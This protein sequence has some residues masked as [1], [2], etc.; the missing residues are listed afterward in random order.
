VLKSGEFKP[1]ADRPYK[2]R[3]GPEHVQ[4][5]QAQFQEK[6]SMMGRFVCLS[7]IDVPG[8]ETIPLQDDLPGWWSK[9]ELF[10]V[11]RRVAYV[12]LDTVI[13]GDPSRYL[14]QNEKR[15]MVS[16]GIHIL[17][18]GA[19]NTSLMAWD[20][21][22][23]WVYDRFMQDPR[24]VMESYVTQCHWGD[25]GF[26]K[27]V[28]R[29]R[30]HFVRFQY[31]YPGCILNYKRDFLTPRPTKSGSIGVWGQVPLMKDW[32]RQPR[33]VFFNGAGK[34]WDYEETW[35]PPLHAKEP[36]AA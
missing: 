20:G 6:A 24:K 10:R 34:P 30:I 28:G 16:T 33:V 32:Q 29:N 15:F 12:D 2:V 19:I 26:L 31:K 3:Y 23:R 35:I 21:D 27:D 25:Q 8:V 14:F 36:C 17:R 7:D 9:M 1:R 4:W 18:Y 5:L 22:Y 11:F 13:I